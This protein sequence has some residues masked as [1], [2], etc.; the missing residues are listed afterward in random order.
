[1]FSYLA[2]SKAY[3]SETVQDSGIVMTS[4]QLIATPNEGAEEIENLSPGVKVRIMDTVDDWY[5]VL[6]INKEQGWLLKSG[7]ELI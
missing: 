5:Q 6:L 2:G 1:M 7:V 4:S 3:S